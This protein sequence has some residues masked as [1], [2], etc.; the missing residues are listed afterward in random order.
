MKKSMLLTTI[1]M[2]VVVV[3]A[4][5]T[6]TFAWFSSQTDTAIEGQMVIEAGA[7]FLFEE[8]KG[9]DWT[10]TSKIDIA[11]NMGTADTGILPVS[12]VRALDKTTNTTQFDY[13][14]PGA[15]ADAHP[16]DNQGVWYEVKGQKGSWS[17]LKVAKGG[18]AI[19][20]FRVK[21]ANGAGPAKLNFKIKA[22]DNAN[23]LIALKSVKVV[24]QVTTYA[25]GG[26]S[27]EGTK[28]YGTQYNYGGEGLV[29]TSTSIGA[30]LST[31][32]VQASGYENAE[33]TYQTANT[34]PNDTLKPLGVVPLYSALQATTSFEDAIKQ[35]VE[36]SSMTEASVKKVARTFQEEITFNAEW[37]QVVAFVWLDGHTAMDDASGKT[38]DI[39]VGFRDPAAKA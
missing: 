4:L 20:K 18:F 30:D 28:Y 19:T 27:V 36:Y 2:I 13:V 29:D 7:D 37:V 34:A 14:A 8:S 39:V 23:G 22:D 21:K 17:A 15:N 38:I 12:P 1:A 31:D 24:L 3:I 16:T 11:A 6:A 25:E 9:S 32:K 26:Q 10:P 33:G 5:S 35:R